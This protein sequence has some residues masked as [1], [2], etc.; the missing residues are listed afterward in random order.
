MS[1]QKL[2]HAILGTDFSKAVA[3]I[4][5]N[6]EMVKTLGIE[7]ISLVH[8]LNL[9]DM[10]SV[11]RFTIEGLGKKLTEQKELLQTKGFEVE[12]EMIF[13][14]PY[15]ELEKKRRE[16]GAQIII[17]GSH[18]RTGSSSTIGGTIA[19]VLQNLKAPVLVVPLEKKE[20]VQPELPMKNFYQYEKI[21]LELQKHEPGWNL[22]CNQLVHHILLPTDFSDFSEEAF[23]YLKEMEEKLPKVTLLHVQDEIKIGKHLDFKLEE[24]NK[25]DTQ[26]LIRL[27]KEFQSAHPETEVQIELLYGKPTQVILNFIKEYEVSLTVMG[28]QGRGFFEGMFMGSVSNQVA[29]HSSSNVLIIPLPDNRTE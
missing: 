13:G 2:H 3:E 10:I 14:I 15:V 16:K 20:A 12:S 27:K 19:D 29:R 11:E 9:R 8:V 18:G 5:D 21:M 7:K 1:N 22:K 26:R 25:I 17:V 23:Q 24:F 28:S 6:S 4:I